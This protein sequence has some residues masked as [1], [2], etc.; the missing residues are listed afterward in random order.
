[1]EYNIYKR[2]RQSVVISPQELVDCSGRYGNYGC[3]GGFFT[4]SNF[5]LLN[6]I[7]IFLNIILKPDESII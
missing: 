4:A 1:M 6:L 2:Q 3:D 7:Q 5:F